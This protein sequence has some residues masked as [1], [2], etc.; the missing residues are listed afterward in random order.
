MPAKKGRGQKMTLADFGGV[1][2]ET[3]DWA[4]D[5]FAP[6]PQTGPAE[7]GDM[8]PAM[9]E[10]K[11][12]DWR[13]YGF[14]VGAMEG[15]FRDQAPVVNTKVVPEDMEA[16]FVAYVGNLPHTIKGETV[17]EQFLHVMDVRVIKNDRS[18]FAY[19]EFENREALQGAILMTGKIV[20]GRKIRV[21]VASDAQR[22]RLEQERGGG[23]GRESAVIG[24][25]GMGAAQPRM[26][27][28]MGSRNASA[29]DL[30][31]SRDAMGQAPQ[32]GSFESP[33]SPTPEF[34][35]DAFGEAKPRTPNSNGGRFGGFGGRGSKPASPAATGAPDFSNWRDSDRTEQPTQQPGSP[36]DRGAPAF[37]RRKEGKSP[38]EE[39]GGSWRD[40]PAA[41]Q[42]EG[43]SWRDAP[44]AAAPAKAP[45]TDDAGS[46]RDS[47][48]VKQ[49]E[50]TG[51]NPW[52]RG[53]PSK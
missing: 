24:R 30:A 52:R 15:N 36:A 7:A 26:G 33:G 17:E 9:G 46:W 35:R 42:P 12:R 41:K 51:E 3:L 4:R 25:D 43:G 11:G 19:V 44:A 5:E 34:S 23:S 22:A 29:M 32:Q 45:K 21:D 50:S 16:P 10:K 6:T 40:A 20:G 39:K 28:R 8:P 37:A 49:P 2:E 53:P 47:K 1:K 27:S 18:T 13:D 31:F 38:N 14:K 48:P